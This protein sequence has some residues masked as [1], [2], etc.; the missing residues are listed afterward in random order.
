MTAETR[1]E[2]AIRLTTTRHG[3]WQTLIETYP[4]HATDREWF[5]QRVADERAW[6]AEDART[7]DAELIS[8][9]VTV[10]E[11][12]A[13]FTP[14][15][16]IDAANAIRNVTNPL[17]KGRPTGRDRTAL[18]RFAAWPGASKETAKLIGM[19][20]DGT[21]LLPIE[22]SLGVHLFQAMNE[23][24][25]VSDAELEAWTSDWESGEAQAAQDDAEHAEQLATR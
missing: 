12:A 20:L 2:Y 25:D 24:P 14:N 19:V 9:T 13:A 5:E 21:I 23:L 16:V 22:D 7:P 1:T 15:Q 10:S 17:F 18:A 3:K 6:Q 4:D 11:W 8:R